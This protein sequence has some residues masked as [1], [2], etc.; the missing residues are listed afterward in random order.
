MWKKEGIKQTIYQ[1][2]CGQF[3]VHACSSIVLRRKDIPGLQNKGSS[4]SPAHIPAPAAL[5]PVFVCFMQCGHSLDIWCLHSPETVISSHPC[6]T[7]S[8]P[9]LL[10]RL[11]WVPQ[12]Q[13]ELKKTLL[14]TMRSCGSHT[15]QKKMLQVEN[16]KNSI[17]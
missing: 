3:S 4:V 12:S 6:V 8:L 11:P 15:G 1:L 5:F 9:P 14:G 17:H 7:D 16:T 2:A 13:L 10:S